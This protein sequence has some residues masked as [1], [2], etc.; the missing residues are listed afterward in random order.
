MSYFNFKAQVPGGESNKRTAD[1]EVIE[2][3]SDDEDTHEELPPQK[4]SR[5]SM[6]FKEKADILEKYEDMKSQDYSYRDMQDI[7][8]ISKSN[9]QRWV[10]DRDSIV[11]K[12]AEETLAN[13]KKSRRS[14]RHQ[15]SYPTLHHEFTKARKAGKKVDFRWLLM[16]GKKI[17]NVKK[18]PTFTKW[19]TERF[20]QI[21]GIKIRTAQNKKSVDKEAQ[22]P[23]IRDFHL[24][25]REK[26]IKSGQNKPHYDPKYGRFKPSRRFNVDQV[27]LPFCLDQKKTYHDCSKGPSRNER[28]RIAQPSAGLEKRQ[29]TLQLCFSPEDNNVRVD[30]VFRGAGMQFNRLVALMSG[31]SQICCLNHRWIITDNVIYITA[32]VSQIWLHI[33]QLEYHI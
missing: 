14:N 2:I 3:A 15:M 5:K 7:L 13:L 30:V 17:A 1:A 19:A 18:G 28:V 33:S 11:A 27:P 25:L 23:K 31:I 21:Y 32:R 12:A 4:R 24:N 9:L 6:S 8:G 10:K 16:K 20:L 22:E 29:C 26:V